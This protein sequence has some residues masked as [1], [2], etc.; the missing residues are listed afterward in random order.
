MGE[1]T[2]KHKKMKTK[3]SASKTAEDVADMVLQ[4]FMENRVVVDPKQQEQAVVRHA[5]R[6]SQQMFSELGA[7]IDIGAN[8]GS[9]H[10]QPHSHSDTADLDYD[11]GDPPVEPPVELLAVR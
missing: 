4:D 6:L 5:K 8:W 11:F 10:D 7:D 2:N 1:K 3:R 9:A